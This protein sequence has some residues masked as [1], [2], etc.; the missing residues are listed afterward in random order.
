MDF[1]HCFQWES[2][3]CKKKTKMDGIEQK[4]SGI[5]SIF[6]DSKL[7]QCDSLIQNTSAYRLSLICPMKHKLLGKENQ[8]KFQF[9]KHLVALLIEMQLYMHKI[10]L[11]RV[12]HSWV[13]VLRSWKL[14]LLFS[15]VLCRSVK[16]KSFLFVLYGSEIW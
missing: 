11:E 3:F 15:T 9:G 7:S 16:V 13:L 12:A 1:H 14:K 4:K 8:Y 5:C 6:V 10:G 2:A